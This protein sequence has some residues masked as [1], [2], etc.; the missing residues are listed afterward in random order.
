MRHY[1]SHVELINARSK[2]S[3]SFSAQRTHTHTRIKRRANCRSIL[4]VGGGTQMVPAFTTRRAREPKD[5]QT[6][7]CAFCSIGMRRQYL[8][9]HHCLAN[10]RRRLSRAF[11]W[12]TLAGTQWQRENGCNLSATQKRQTCVVLFGARPVVRPFFLFFLPNSC[13]YDVKMGL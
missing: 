11:C 7:I 3:F 12:S 13:Y 6:A 8:P 5:Q 10:T 4:L 2:G 1:P 9:R